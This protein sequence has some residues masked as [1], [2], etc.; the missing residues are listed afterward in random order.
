MA[1]DMT[2]HQT[3]QDI[4]DFWY[5]EVTYILYIVGIKI[6]IKPNTNLFTRQ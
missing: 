3:F 6:F 5:G 4:K 1:Y 2:V